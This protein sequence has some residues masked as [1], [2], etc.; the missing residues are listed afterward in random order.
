MKRTEEAKWN[1][2]PKYCKYHHLVGHAIQDCFV[3]KDKVMQLARQGRISLEEDSAMTNAIT[4]EN[5][6]FDG[7]KDSCNTARGDVTTSNEDTLLKNEDSFNVDDLK[8]VIGDSKLFTETESHFADVKYY[9]EDAKKGKEVFPSEEQKSCGY[10]PKEKL[11][12]EK[13]PPQ[14]IGKKLDGLNTT[15]VMLKEKGHAIQDSRVGLGF[16]PPKPARIAIK[17]V[18]NNYVA[19]GFSST[20]DDKGEDLR[21]FVFNILGPHRRALHEITN[22]QSVFDRNGVGEDI[23]QTYHITLI[24]DGE[25]EEEDTKDAP[26]ELEEGVKATVDELKEVNLCNIEITYVL[27][28][29]VKGQFLADFLADHPMPAEWELSDD[30]PDED[31][32]VIEITPPWKCTLMES[33]I[34]KELVLE[35]LFITSE[36]EVLPYSFTKTQNCSNN[37]A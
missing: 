18:S 21:E 17:R 1:N 3:F 37:A 5:G 6:Y 11:S 26:V 28:K 13:L 20:E 36:G 9:I 16:T 35:L 8:R 19:E 12:L 15:Q 7:N 29:A 31:V 23:A 24:E 30:L 10:N 32:L 4:I 33:L 27:Q 34:K 14:A 25:V 2:D 22:K